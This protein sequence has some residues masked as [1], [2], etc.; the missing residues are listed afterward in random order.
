MLIWQKLKGGESMKVCVAKTMKVY[1]AIV[2]R[3][4]AALDDTMIAAF[5]D[6]S[7]AR[8]FVAECL[9]DREYREGYSLAEMNWTIEEREVIE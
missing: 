6:M 2:Q 7:S 5:A 4:M 1:V 3:P 9:W 8:S